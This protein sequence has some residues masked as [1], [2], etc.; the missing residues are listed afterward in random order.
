[1]DVHI[2][3]YVKLFVTFYG[4]SGEH[5]NKDTIKKENGRKI[6]I[7]FTLECCLVVTC[8]SQKAFTSYL[9]ILKKA[10]SN[11]SRLIMLTS[12]H[13]FIYMRK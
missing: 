5:I 3:I 4:G 10:K 13:S 8:M 9:D 2:H 11:I 12:I 6:D 1:M 7:I